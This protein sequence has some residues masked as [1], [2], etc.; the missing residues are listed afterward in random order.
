[1]KRIFYLFSILMMLLACADDDTFSTSS[2]LRLTFSEDT[3]SLDTLFSKTPSA[4]Y[5]FWVHNRNNDGLRLQSVRLNKRNQTGFRVN[6]DGAY[7]DNTTGSQVNDLEL[8]SKDSLLVFVELTSQE[9]SQEAPKLIEDDLIFRLESGTEQKVNLRAWSWDAQKMY[10]L[11]VTKDSVIESTKPIVLYGGM[12][13]AKGATLTIRNTTL[14]FHD[15]RGIDVY[16]RL[17]TDSVIMRGDRLDRMFD[18]LPYDRVSG[19][20][21]TEGGIIF[22]ESSTANVLYRTE[23]RNAGLYGILCDSAA[24]DA[25]VLRLDMQQCVVHNCKGTGLA[26][27]NANIRLRE[28]QFS[29]TLG[30][31][32][33]INGGNAEIKRCTMAQFYPFSAPRGAALLFA[34]SLPLYGLTCDSSI[35]TGYEEDVLMGVLADTT[36][37]FEFQFMNTLLRTPRVETGDSVR[38]SNIIWETPK[39]SIQGKQHFRII[40]EDNLF[41]DFH[42]DSLSTAKEWGCY[43]L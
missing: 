11:T 36:N 15:G 6:V 9:T 10:N 25:S 34:N 1:M 13:V 30:D 5:A 42:L 41:Y 4:T 38:F 29:N 19:Q 27:I 28:C 26:S 22:H 21:G 12:T 16:G 24:Y 31:C 20:W 14:Y 39:D 37:V 7:L 43:P 32:I 2:G 23:I 8:R 35:V 18:Y 33:A 17:V 40:D 3:V